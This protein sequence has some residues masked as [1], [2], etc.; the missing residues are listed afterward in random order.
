MSFD[1]RKVKYQQQNLF[2][3]NLSDFERIKTD[4]FDSFLGLIKS[5]WDMQNEV[6]STN[7]RSALKK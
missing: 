7:I 4:H 6:R 3:Q 1:L 2:E 5:V